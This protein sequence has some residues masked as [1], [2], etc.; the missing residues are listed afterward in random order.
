MRTVYAVR[1]GVQEAGI[2]NCTATK[3]VGCFENS[4]AEFAFKLAGLSLA[5]ERDLEVLE[6][7]SHS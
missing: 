6:K 4:G 2:S 3:G 5:I 7:S 1:A